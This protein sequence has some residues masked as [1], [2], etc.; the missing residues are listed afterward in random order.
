M[1]A[2]AKHPIAIAL[3][4]TKIRTRN[5]RLDHKKQNPAGNQGKGESNQREHDTDPAQ[6]VH[7]YPLPL[8]QPAGALA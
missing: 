2:S 5:R 6:L 1:P 4:A 3:K 8:S 7:P